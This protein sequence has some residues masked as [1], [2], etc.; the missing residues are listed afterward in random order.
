MKSSPLI[1][2]LVVPFIAWRIYARAR[3]NIGRQR[4]QPRNLR[5]RAII[6]GVLTGLVA[7]LA[8]SFPASLGGL[9]GGLTLGVLLALLGLRLTRFETTAEGQFYTP[10]TYLGV[11]V[12]LLLVGRILYR[13]LVL[14]ALTPPD[15]APPLPLFQSPLTFLFFGL[16]AGYYIA[17]FAGVVIE[18]KRLTPATKAPE[19][20]RG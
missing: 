6:F 11:A 13:V 16:T 19:T 4:L 5:V 2:A 7:L 10:N 3:R 14:V 20:D 12:T 15:A 17:Y 9:A 8:L 1:P 18:A